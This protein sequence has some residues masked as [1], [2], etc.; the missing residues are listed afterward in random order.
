MKKK[1]KEINSFKPKMISTPQKY[2][3]KN[4]NSFEDREKLYFDNKNKHQ[5]K[6]INKI[7]K[8]F[9]KNFSFTPKI[10]IDNYYLKNNDFSSHVHLRLYEDEQKRR[11]KKLNNYNSKINEKCN[12]KRKDIPLVDYEKIEENK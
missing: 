2:R 1:K 7:D 4:K 11:N 8:D 12:S 3:I 9:K 5:Q 10:N 6:L